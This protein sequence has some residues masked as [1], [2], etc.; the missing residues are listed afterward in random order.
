ME[1][2]ASFIF[3]HPGQRPW[4][5]VARPRHSTAAVH[6]SQGARQPRRARTRQEI[7]RKE[8]IVT[9]L[10]A[11]LAPPPCRPPGVGWAPGPETAA[12]HGVLAERPVLAARVRHG[13]LL[14]R[15]ALERR[16]AQR[17]PLAA[18]PDGGARADAQAASGEPGDGVPPARDVALRGAAQGRRRAEAEHVEGAAGHPG[19]VNRWWRAKGSAIA[20][21]ANARLSAR[22][23]HPASS[24][25]NS[26]TRRGRLVRL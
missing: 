6:G 22:R 18:L 5:P 17:L 3:A 24:G 11:P 7:T 10:G 8:I 1:L 20:G 15:G 14:A 9:G 13:P 16:R 4:F 12:G 26:V 19:E 25:C 2:N 21:G 23:P